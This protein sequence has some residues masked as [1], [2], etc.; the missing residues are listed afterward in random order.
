MLAAKACFNL[1]VVLHYRGNT[2][3]LYFLFP[4][5]VF[6]CVRYSCSLSVSPCCFR[7]SVFFHLLLYIYFL[8][9]YKYLCR[10]A[11]LADLPAS[12]N[13]LYTHTYSYVFYLVI[14]FPDE[15]RFMLSWKCPLGCKQF[16][17]LYAH[18]AVIYFLKFLFV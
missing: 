18:F 4:L 12:T 5:F 17:F 7:T 14:F 10:W 15:S 6:Y 16:K 2:V 3:R 13:I 1:L 9:L 11:S 8:L